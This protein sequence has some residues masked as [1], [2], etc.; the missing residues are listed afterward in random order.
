VKDEHVA[1]FRDGIAAHFGYQETLINGEPNP[2]TKAV[3]SKRKLR[4]QMIIWV[5]QAERA[6]AIEAVPDATEIDINE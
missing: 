6:A 5:K 4:Q 2:E 1:R 3:Y